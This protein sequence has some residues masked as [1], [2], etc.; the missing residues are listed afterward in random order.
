MAGVGYLVQASFYRDKLW[1]RVNPQ[2][3]AI[4]KEV[5]DLAQQL[6]PQPLRGTTVSPSI[7]STFNKATPIV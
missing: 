3:S 6:A 2:R 1:S 5:R 7:T 4:L